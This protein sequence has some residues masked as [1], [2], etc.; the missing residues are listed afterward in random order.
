[1]LALPQVDKELSSKYAMY[2]L[3]LKERG[4]VNEQ[5]KAVDIGLIY[6]S[7]GKVQFLEDNKNSFGWFYEIFNT[8]N[9][10]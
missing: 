2:T 6:N 10:S 7:N 4:G 3:E 8:K 5:I 1:M 9:Y